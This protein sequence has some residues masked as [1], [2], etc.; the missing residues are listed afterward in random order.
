VFRDAPVLDESAVHR[1]V[2]DNGLSQSRLLCDKVEKSVGS[3]IV[4]SVIAK[5]RNCGPG[6][7]GIGYWSIDLTIK[8]ESK[9]PAMVEV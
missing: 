3:N 5:K 4:V 2:I 7:H 9:L 1:F 8:D 6:N